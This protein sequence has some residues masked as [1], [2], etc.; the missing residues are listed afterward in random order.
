MK[1]FFLTVTLISVAG[2]SITA[3]AIAKA[4]K[5][6]AAPQNEVLWD[7]WYI[8]AGGET[9]KREIHYINALS[10]KTRVDNEAI[11]SGK[12]DARNPASFVE[13]DGVAVFE[14]AKNKPART[15]GKV[16][17]RCATNQMMFLQSYRQYWKADRF[18]QSP[19]TAWFDANSD[20]KFQKIVHFLCK[21][22]ERNDKNKMMRVYQKEDPLDFTWDVA[23]NEVPK[24]KFTTS[25]TLAQAQ[26]DFDKQVARN[27]ATIDRGTKE[28]TEKRL[29]ML[30]DEKVTA[31]EQ[32]ALF[33]KMRGKASPLLHSWLGASDRDL[34]ASWGN[35]TSY[36][37]ASGARFM[38]YTEGYATQMQD[39]YGNVQAGSRQEFYCNMTFEV[40]AGL[41]KDYRSD[42]NY[43]GAGSRGKPRGPN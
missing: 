34:V 38:T 9:P 2:L 26:A 15:N 27:Q 24:P 41:I 17:V 40:S 23:W 19:P 3:P 20:Y 10:V 18:E 29:Q 32:R 31:M 11:L 8:W 35:P 25:K 22:K 42:G 16:R 30:R 5:A 37:D 39:Q 12:F 13:A 21:P 33:S 7:W 43:C 36:Y 4:K 1:Y 28:F 6:A 14:D